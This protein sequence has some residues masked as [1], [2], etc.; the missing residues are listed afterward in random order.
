MK[1][2]LSIKNLYVSI[3]NKEIIKGINLDIDQGTTHAIMGPNG[4]GKSTL[5]LSL[6]GHP[7]YLIQKGEILFEDKN[8]INLSVDERAKLGMFLALQHPYEI[9]GVTLRDFLRQS[10]NSIYSDKHLSPKEFNDLLNQ[11]MN[12]LNINESF[13][14]RYLN[15]GFSG[16]EKK[17]AETLQMAVLNPK[18]IILD[19]LDSGLD[20]DALQNVCKAINKLKELNPKLSILVIT[21]YQRILKFLKP[22]FVHVMQNGKIIK[23]GEKEL[24]EELEKVGYKKD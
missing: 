4:S 8:I 15:V 3:K 11:K 16:G 10:Y 17:L 9:E 18:F 7:K 14:D 1:H 23:S 22:D 6:M 13:V 21:H 12:D 24:A 19:E 5:A 2:L 20:I